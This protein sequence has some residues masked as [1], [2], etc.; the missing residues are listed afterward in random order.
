[1]HSGLFVNSVPVEGTLEV[2]GDARNLLYEGSKIQIASMPAQG[3][4][5]LGLPS[6]RSQDTKVS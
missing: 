2:S 6:I 3:H 5:D 4:V 1:M